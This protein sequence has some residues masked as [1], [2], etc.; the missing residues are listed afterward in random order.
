MLRGLL[1]IGASVLLAACQDVQPQRE[2]SNNATS[3]EPK[4]FSAEF[5]PLD[6][7]LKLTDASY[8][9][10]FVYFRDGS[11]RLTAH[12]DP[13][14]VDLDGDG[15]DEIIFAGFET[16]PNTP[17]NFSRIDI[18]I[19][20]WVGN[21]LKNISNSWLPNDAGYIF[22]TSEII[23]GDFNGDGNV[24]IFL[25]AYADMEHHFTPFVLMNQGDYFIKKK[26]PESLTWQHG[27]D[28]ADINA[29]GFDDVYASGYQDSSGIYFG[30]PDGLIV[31]TWTNWAGGSDV[32]L[33]D[34]L[35]KGKIEA[36]IT[37]HGG[38]H[39]DTVLAHII[40]NEAK[41]TARLKDISRLPAPIMEDMK[42]KKWRESHDI[43][44][45]SFDF[46]YDGL[47]DVI[48]L[49]ENWI[50]E[51]AK[52]VRT[53][54]QFLENKGKGKF[55]DVTAK[56]SNDGYRTAVPYNTLQPTD[57]NRDGKLDIFLDGASDTDIAPQ[58]NAAAILLA[59]Q[60][61]TFTSI[62][63]DELSYGISPFKGV[64]TIAKGPS[65]DYFQILLD[66]AYGKA[67]VYYRKLTFTSK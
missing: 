38:T 34:F 58:H 59:N 8:A 18:Q 6:V 41:K 40:I 29:D 10:S 24:D 66:L 62:G 36:L 31:Y 60:N 15:I 64:S 19:F 21:K 27:G 22:G 13:L 65:G 45:I 28:S 55:V 51:Q 17:S 49:S 61:N 57:F 47:L 37:D 30:S 46:N 44:S 5:I 1:I 52:S 9:D 50:N 12:Q 43:R 67:D 35:G 16:Q 33:G 54:A 32:S 56:Y 23:P 63:N 4:S 53:I 7:K 42:T 39:N 48:V 20:G 2:L 25:P 11:T 14:P 3:D 26:L